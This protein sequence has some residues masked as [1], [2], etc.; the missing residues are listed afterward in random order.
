M[1]ENTLTTERLTVRSCACVFVNVVFTDKVF[2]N[3][4]M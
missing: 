2:V 1:S 4:S 3:V